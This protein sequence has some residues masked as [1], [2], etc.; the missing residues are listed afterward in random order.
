MTFEKVT[1][2][3]LPVDM[4]NSHKE[5]NRSIKQMLSLI[6]TTVQVKTFIKKKIKLHKFHV[7]LVILYAYESCASTTQMDKK[8]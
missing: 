8:D 7:R 5:I 1:F 6:S 2:K 3:Y 4:N